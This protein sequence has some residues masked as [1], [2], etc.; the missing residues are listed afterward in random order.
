ME[1]VFGTL[2]PGTKIALA[3]HMGGQKPLLHT[4]SFGATLPTLVREPHYTVPRR[5]LGKD[6]RNVLTHIGI[7]EYGS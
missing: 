6:E 5:I 3:P 2:A 4:I 1:L 7:E